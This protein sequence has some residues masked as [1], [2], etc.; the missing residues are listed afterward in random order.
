MDTYYAHSSDAADKSDWQT[1][2]EHL[3]G[4]AEKAMVFAAA[5]EAQEWGRCAGLLHDAGKATSAFQRRLEG[6]SK[7]PDHHIGVMIGIHPWRNQE[8]GFFVPSFDPHE[9]VL[10]IPNLAPHFFQF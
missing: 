10:V 3:I 9:L 5:F 6:C 4:V 8:F 2:S 7:N 1:L